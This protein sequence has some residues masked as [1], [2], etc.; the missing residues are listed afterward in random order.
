MGEHK[1][2]TTYLTENVGLGAEGHRPAQTMRTCGASSPRL[3]AAP[4]SE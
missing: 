3:R 2:R 4:R 1:D